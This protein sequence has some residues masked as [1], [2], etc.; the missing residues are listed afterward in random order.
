[1]RRGIDAVLFDFGGVLA[2]EGFRN[3]LYEIASRNGMD[4]AAFFETARLLIASTGYLTGRSTEARYFAELRRRMGL[5]EDDVTMRKTIL[6]GFVMRPWMVDLVKRLAEN[7]I[8]TAVL[9]D[10][11]D[12]LDELEG[13]LGFSR[14]FERVFNSYHMGK[15]KSDPSLFKDVLSCMGLEAAR[16]LFVDDTEGHVERARSVGI[17]AVHYRE[18]E[19]ALREISSFFPGIRLVT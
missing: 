4:P 6:D 9:S 14:L 7:G 1:M 18:R 8:R 17:N 3:G 2:E 12:W 15:S 13:R 10:Q 11:T 16:T 5:R 19:Q